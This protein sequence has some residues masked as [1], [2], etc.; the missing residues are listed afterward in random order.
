MIGW[1]QILPPAARVLP[2]DTRVCV[3]R[4]SRE[5]ISAK[6]LECF[7][8]GEWIENCRLFRVLSYIFS[9]GM[10]SH[11][12]LEV[13]FQLFLVQCYNLETRACNPM[14]RLAEA[15]GNTSESRA[16]IGCFSSANYYSNCEPYLVIQTSFKMCIMFKHINE[17]HSIT[18]INLLIFPTTS[19]M[20]SI[21]YSDI[22]MPITK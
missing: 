4:H 15:L 20:K 13:S 22:D 11:F 9:H 10:A 2:P 3:A 21:D 17:T 8:S 5:T 1:S 18:L 16:L 19:H 6:W 14:R 7:F 12:R